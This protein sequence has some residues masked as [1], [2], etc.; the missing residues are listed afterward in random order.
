MTCGIFIL[1]KNKEVVAPAGPAPMMHIAV[2]IFVT[3]EFIYCKA[4]LSQLA[5][6]I[7]SENI[8]YNF[9][10]SKYFY[11]ITEKTSKSL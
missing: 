4:L 11:V 7:P 1:D 9:K 6:V 5:Y 2:L 3:E 8:N 10:K